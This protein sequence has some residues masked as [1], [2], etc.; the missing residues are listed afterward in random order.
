VL[1]ENLHDSP[2]RG[3][4]LVDVDHGTNGA[5]IL[6]LEDSAQSVGIELVRAD[7]AKVRLVCVTNEDIADH[8][9]QLASGFVVLRG[10]STDVDRVFTKVGKV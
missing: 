1:T 9:S 8:L 5:A 7:Q 2:V 6:D 10:R 3:Q 4:V